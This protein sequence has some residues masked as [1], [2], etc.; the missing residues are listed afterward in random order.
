MTKGM[1]ADVAFNPINVGLFGPGSGNGSG[2]WLREPCGAVWAVGTG[3]SL[4]CDLAA[5]LAALFS[6]RQEMDCK[7]QCN[8]SWLTTRAVVIR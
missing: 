2:A 7:L 8:S 3:Q 4:A 5:F 6:G 1:K